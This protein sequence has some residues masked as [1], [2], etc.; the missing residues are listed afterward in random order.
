MKKWDSIK[1]KIFCIAK[2][3]KPTTI[4]KGVSRFKRLPTEWEKNLF[5]F[6]FGDGDSQTTARV[7]LNCDPL[8]L[9]FSSS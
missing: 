1:L 9:I 5:F 6:Y 7:I 8:H 3:Q 2:K 4:T